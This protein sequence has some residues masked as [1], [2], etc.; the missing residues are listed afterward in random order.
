MKYNITDLYFAKCRHSIMDIVN[1]TDESGH[2]VTPHPDYLEYYTILLL[3]NNEYINIYNKNI[4]YKKISEVTDKESNC[5]ADLIIEIYNLTK[6]INS[7]YKKISSKECE[8]I[9]NTIQKTKS[10]KIKYGYKN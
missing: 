1:V 4:K 6:Y 10:L 3:K 7:E 9:G 2:I 5:E 8:L